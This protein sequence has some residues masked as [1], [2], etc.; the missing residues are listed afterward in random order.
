[1]TLSHLCFQKLSTADIG[2]EAHEE[3]KL[4]TDGS[5][6]NYCSGLGGRLRGKRKKLADSEYI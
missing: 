4:H 3:A 1:M 5:E 6:G 2:R